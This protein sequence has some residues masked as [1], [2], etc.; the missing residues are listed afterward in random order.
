MDLNKIK[1]GCFTIKMSHGKFNTLTCQN[2]KASYELGK[3]Q[4]RKNLI[5]VCA[6][7]KKQI[8][9]MDFL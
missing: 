9:I 5:F 4:N 2:K 6:L 8:M 3:V 7:K 1:N